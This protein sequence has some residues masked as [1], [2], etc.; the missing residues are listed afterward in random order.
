MVIPEKG[1]FGGF[2]WAHF[3]KHG[4]AGQREDVEVLTLDGLWKSGTMRSLQFCKCDTEGSELEVIRGGLE[5]IK[6]ESPGWLMEVSRATSSELFGLLNELR[7][8]SFVY[9]GGLIPTDGCRVEGFSNYF[10]FSPSSKTWQ[11]VL[12]LIHDKEVGILPLASAAGRSTDR[13][14][15]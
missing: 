14:C 3:A 8:Q 15:R 6:S 9:D 4:D 13:S 11:R 7:Y 12:P 5:L 10:F 2:Y 1:E